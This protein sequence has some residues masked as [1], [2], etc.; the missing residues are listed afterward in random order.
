MLIAATEGPTT[1]EELNPR[2]YTRDVRKRTDARGWILEASNHA[3]GTWETSARN[4][5]RRACEQD[6]RGA[7]AVRVWN[8]KG[9]LIQVVLRA[10]ERTSANLIERA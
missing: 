9:E 1:D 2:W 4:A 10:R 7:V 6:E 8:G 3:P 5:V